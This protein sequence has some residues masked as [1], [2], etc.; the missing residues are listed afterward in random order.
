MLNHKHTTSCEAFNNKQ[1]LL[2]RQI[3][4][5]CIL[6][7]TSQDVGIWKRNKPF[8]SKIFQS[9]FNSPLKLNFGLDLLSVIYLYV[10]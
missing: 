8:L 10:I 4:I 7:P 6:H 1:K 5:F 2:E 9:F 3:N